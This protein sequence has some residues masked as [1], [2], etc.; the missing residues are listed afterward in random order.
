MEDRK[1]TNTILLMYFATDIY[2]K[3]H[4]MTPVQFSEL[5][6]KRDI[7]HFISE[8]PEYY[9]GMRDSEMLEDLDGYFSGL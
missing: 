7:I 5:C 2:C 1:L 3:A 9:D 8:C 4:D 6:E